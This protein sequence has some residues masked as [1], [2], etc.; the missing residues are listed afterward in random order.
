MIM[1]RNKIKALI[2]WHLCL[3]CSGYF[4]NHRFKIFEIISL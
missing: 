3:E 2:C 4:F 1:V